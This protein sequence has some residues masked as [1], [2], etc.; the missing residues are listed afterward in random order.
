MYP[1]SKKNFDKV[2][3]AIF[4]ISGLNSDR[5]LSI[6]YLPL[7]VVRVVDKLRKCVNKLQ[8]QVDVSV[9]K[10]KKGQKAQSTL[11]KNEQI[12]NSINL[13]YYVK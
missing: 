12:N 2:I 5:N 10:T 9:V 8:N 11:L 4:L 13:K 7:C 3:S 6:G 1:L